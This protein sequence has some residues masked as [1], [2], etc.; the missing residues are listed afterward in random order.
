MGENT[1]NA[2]AAG[3]ITQVKAGT[4][5]SVTIHQVNADGAGPYTCDLD[6]TGNSLGATGQTALA[7]TN[8]VPGANGFSQAKTVDFNMTVTMPTDLKCTGGSTGNICTVRCRNNALAG[9]FGKRS[10][11]RPPPP[12]TRSLARAKT[13]RITDK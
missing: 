13:S 7:V 5:L 12:Q 3:Q 4:P 9:P 10:R 1:E 11:R 2:L 8:N 6:P